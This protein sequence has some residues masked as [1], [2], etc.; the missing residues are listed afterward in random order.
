MLVGVVNAVVSVVVCV[1]G[2]SNPT[3]K[4]GLLYSVNPECSTSDVLPLVSVLPVAYLG[5]LSAVAVEV[6][7]ISVSSWV[8]PD[9]RYGL[10]KTN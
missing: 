9:T 4:L 1:W 7:L 6:C 2:S 10:I 5:R 8:M 3:V